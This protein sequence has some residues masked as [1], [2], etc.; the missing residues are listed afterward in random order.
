MHNIYLLHTT[1]LDYY[2]YY[3]IYTFIS[4]LFIYN[5]Y[6]TFLILN[7]CQMLISK[8]WV[9]LLIKESVNNTVIVDRSTRLTSKITDI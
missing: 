8:E 3:Y 5:C 1:L 2:Y 7:F 9:S 4:L 6:K